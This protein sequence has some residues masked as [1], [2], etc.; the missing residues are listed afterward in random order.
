MDLRKKFKAAMFDFDGTLTE[1]GENYPPKEVAD[2]LVNLSQKMPI[3]FCTGRQLESFKA[4][5]LSHLLEQVN[6]EEKPRFIKNLYLF[7]E[8]GALGYDF[9][10]TK[11]DFEEIYRVKWPEEFIEREKLRSILNEE[12]K[13]YGQILYNA[14]EIVVVMGSKYYYE[15][16]P[17]IDKVYELSGK[18]YEITLKV[19]AKINPEYERFVHVGNSGIGVL[20]SPAQGDK[21]SAIEKF[22]QFL[23]QTRGLNFEKDYRDVLVAGDSAQVGGNDFYF[24]NGRFGT[25]FSVGEI[26]PQ[27]SSLQSIFDD[28]GNRLLHADGTLKLIK[29]L[30]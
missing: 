18:I 10:S 17:N 1:K 11:N 2:A 9:D 23:E 20:I 21:D 13:E 6:E 8:N 3:G 28:A 24:L 29:S 22:G 14:H 16:N 27:N 25:P 19:L 4:R 30:L 5:A 26:L 7:A 15:E 12:I